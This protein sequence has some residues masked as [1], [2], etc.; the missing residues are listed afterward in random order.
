MI[1]PRFACFLFRFQCCTRVTV[2]RLS[3]YRRRVLTPP[4]IKFVSFVLFGFVCLFGLVCFRFFFNAAPVSPYRVCHR[5]AAV[6]LPLIIKF[7]CFVL[8]GSF[9]LFSFLLQCCNRVTV[10]RLSPYRRRV[11]TPPII[12]ICLF[13]FVWFVWFVFV[14]SSVLHPC[15]RTPFVTENR[16]KSVIWWGLQSGLVAVVDRMGAKI[17]STRSFG[18]DCEVSALP[19]WSGWERKSRQIGHLVGIARWGL[20]R[21]GGVRHVWPPR[22]CPSS[23][24]RRRTPRAGTT[25]SIYLR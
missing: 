7:V 14:S 18:E 8:F 25:S 19:W 9:G 24:S 2:P 6:S 5:T 10:P 1:D 17:A 11:L 21:V 3:P 22:R 15:H 4:I 13:C 16:V 12:K 23:R 20:R